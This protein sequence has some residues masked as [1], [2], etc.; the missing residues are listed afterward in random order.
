VTG[1]ADAPVVRDSSGVL[2]VDA[3]GLHARLRGMRADTAGRTIRI[4]AR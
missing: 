4:R 2:L 3:K 1:L